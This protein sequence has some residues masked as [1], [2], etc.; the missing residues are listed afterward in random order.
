M[1][2]PPRVRA[3]YPQP[4]PIRNLFDAIP[5][6]LPDEIM[7]T[8]LK[9]KGMRIERIISQGH[10]S[11]PGFW[12]DQAEDEWILLLAGRAELQFEDEAKARALNPGDYLLIPAHRRHRVAWTDAD[13]VTIW[14]AIFF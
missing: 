6:H 8:L 2:L 11:P 3:A 1:G 4:M 12:Y 13:A 9:R 14:L 10:A 7:E 5:E